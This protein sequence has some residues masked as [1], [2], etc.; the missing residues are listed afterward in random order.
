MRFLLLSHERAR[1]LVHFR[2]RTW[3]LV[4]LCLV[5][6]GADAAFAL[7]FTEPT[8]L[9]AAQELHACPVFKESLI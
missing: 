3:A 1:G 9:V 7:T 2:R 6:R 4:A 8:S 5:A